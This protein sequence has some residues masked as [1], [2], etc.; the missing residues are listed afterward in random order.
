MT[1]SP[2]TFTMAVLLISVTV[3]VGALAQG[4][5][6]DVRTGEWEMTMGGFEMPAAALE[7]LP[8]GARGQF[9]TEM[10]KPHTSSSCISAADLKNLNIGKTGDDDDKD[11]TVT[12]KAVT[13]TTADFT[14]QCAGDE[15]RTDV[16]HLEASTPTSFR[17]SIKS[18]TA[19]GTVAMTLTGKW[20][21]ATCKDDK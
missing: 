3:A 19:D 2:R 4:A 10:R 13:R 11:C 17:A 9:Q 7:K 6:F 8:A 1:H 14:R 12:S 20:L 18:T 5:T 21:S 16:M 15:K